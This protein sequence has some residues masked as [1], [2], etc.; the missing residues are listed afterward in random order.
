MPT[1]DFYL[2]DQPRFREDPLLLVCELARKAFDQGMPT[3]ILVRDTGE[4][5]ALDEKLWSFDDDAYVAHQIAGDEDDD[6]TPV[7]IVPPAFDAPAR[8]LVINLRD[9]IPRGRLDVV[10][11]VVPAD[12]AAREGSRRRWREYQARGFTLR[13]FDM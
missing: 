8:P 2:I 9:E 6:L 1:A 11:E 7:L 13:K 3:L 5:E 4:A 12:P 10:K